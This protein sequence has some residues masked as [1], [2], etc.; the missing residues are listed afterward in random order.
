VDFGWKIGAEKLINYFTQ[1]HQEN[2][3]KLHNFQN[4]PTH[5]NPEVKINLRY[6]T[7]GCEFSSS[8]FHFSFS[9][10]FLDTFFFH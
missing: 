10:L 3:E 9:F 7:Y 5:K 6:K 8:F 4:P 1:K 2:P